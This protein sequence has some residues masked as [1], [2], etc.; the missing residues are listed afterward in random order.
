MLIYMHGFTSGW[1]KVRCDAITEYQ[2]RINTFGA[3]LFSLHY[4][5]AKFLINWF[6]YITRTGTNLFM[7]RV[8]L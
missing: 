6:K 8:R 4:P 2:K 3:A 1:D 5:Y 7:I